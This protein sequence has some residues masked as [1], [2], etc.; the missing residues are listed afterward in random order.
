MNA[1]LHSTA[2]QTKGQMI[3]TSDADVLARELTDVRQFTLAL[4]D[5]YQASGM[6]E[7]PRSAEFNPPLWEL[8]HIGWFQQW[9]V[10]RNQLRHLGVACDPTHARLPCPYLA[11]ANHGDDWYNS[12]TVAHTTRWVLPLQ[13]PDATKAYLQAGLMQTL[14]CLD[15]AGEGDANLYFFRLILLHEAMHCEAAVYM[16]QALACPVS[17]P[18]QV[19]S[20]LESIAPHAC[21]IRDADQFYLK[22]QVF[23]A[24]V[25]GGGFAFDNEL[26]GQEVKLNAFEI[27]A[28]PVSWQQYLA[29]V[30]TT[31]H[32]LPR[33]LR[34]VA[35]G[36]ETLLFGRW[37]PLD[38]QASAV[39]LSWH[40]AQ[41]Y[42]MWAQRRLPTEFE[43]ECAAHAQEGF[44]W[45]SVW[46]WTSS[47]FMPYAG[48]QAHPYRDYSEPWFGSR[49]VLKGACAATLPIMRHAKYR[50]YFT[51]DRTDIYAGFRTC[52]LSPRH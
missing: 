27:D 45:G 37:Q 49:K 18:E 12:S 43:W 48:F 44:A 50:N 34:K 22:S 4:F 38:L 31:G 10:G 20:A 29:F 46:E 32:R 7:V 17:M 25:L 47:D 19:V 2:E 42:C 13:G 26:V 16:A 39:H 35:T 5:A 14:R 24:G 11:Q 6:A 51:P 23:Q 9:W 8:G 30:D 3:R 15:Q 52:S 33:Y 1:R 21:D 36:F 41:A 28:S 40:D